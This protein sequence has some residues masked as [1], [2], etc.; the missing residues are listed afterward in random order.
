MHLWLTARRWL[1][2]AAKN[3]VNCP[4]TGMPEIR[5]P[6]WISEASRSSDLVSSALSRSAASAAQRRARLSNARMVAACDQTPAR[7]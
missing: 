1:K 5:A 3:S 6:D 7:E 2:L 4:L